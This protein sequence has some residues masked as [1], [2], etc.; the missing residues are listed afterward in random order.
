[1]TTSDATRLIEAWAQAWSSP[2][3]LEE[4]FSLLTDDCVYKGAIPTDIKS[5]YIAIMKIHNPKTQ[6]LIVLIVINRS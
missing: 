6:T 2:N 1:M 4:L 3:G 5:A